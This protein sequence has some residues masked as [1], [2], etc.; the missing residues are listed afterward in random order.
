MTVGH[1][2]LSKKLDIVLMELK[3]LKAKLSRLK[4]SIQ[5]TLTVTVISAGL[6]DLAQAAIDNVANDVVDKIVDV[7]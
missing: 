1:K 4:Q 2:L 5:D 6:Q 7:V 3:N